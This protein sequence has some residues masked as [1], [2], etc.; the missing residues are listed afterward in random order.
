MNAN[1]INIKNHYPH[2]LILILGA[3]IVS[4]S[5]TFLQYGIDGGLI[6]ANK[7][8]YPDTNSPML[9]YYLNSWTA[10]HQ[11]SY[12]LIKLGV[13]VE[14]AS[15]I[16]ILGSTIF[17][18][19]G[20]FLF[21]N[22][23]TQN[24]NLSI[25][26]SLLAILIG[27]NFGDTDYPSLIYS[28]H[29]YG[30]VSLSLV[31]FSL[32]LFA[33]KNLIPASAITI[34]LIAIHPLIGLWMLAVNLFGF[35]FTK[36]NRREVFKGVTIGLFCIIISFIFF[37]TNSVEKTAYDH[38]LFLNYLDN[39]DGHRAI[40]KVIH[41]DYLLKTFILGIL[42]FFFLQKKNILKNKDN[43]YFH[44]FVLLISLTGSTILYLAYKIAP[45]YFPE[46]IKIAMPTRFI[47]LHTFLGWPIIISLLYF[48]LKERFNKKII[49]NIFLSFLLIVSLQNYK[50]VLDI[51][52][53]IIDAHTANQTYKT[54]DYLKKA[55]FK[56]Y[57]LTSSKLTSKIFKK[58]EK[59]ILLHTDSMDFIPYHPYLAN[60]F[61]NILN[62]IYKINSSKPPVQNNPSLPDKYIKELFENFNQLEWKEI[63]K[64]FNVHY[65]IT[66]KDWNL[67]LD[68]I[69]NDEIYNL[70]K[71]L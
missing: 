60:Q 65:V 15:K 28:E 45:N 14:D 18:S 12:I 50:K 17:F 66:P 7:I 53:S 61:F 20:V 43:S 42:I 2:I 57:I 63:K 22:S 4:L 41:Y 3:L 39:W 46:L 70:Y 23:I 24:K 52:N 71:I 55:N 56:G 27:K 11:I 67:D 29:T 36:I 58:V 8:V 49:L 33:N 34:F 5:H 10:I 19:F 47:M 40:T 26:I 31:T 37:Y 16:I 59:P 44:I 32:G 6:L 62:K 54:L 38:N 30:M 25:I 9:F 51:K 64:E 69:L 13:S 21:S 35:F 1:T 68:L 48:F